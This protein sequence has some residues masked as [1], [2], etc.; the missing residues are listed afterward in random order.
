MNLVFHI[1]ED[2]SEID[3]VYFSLNM[4]HL[5]WDTYLHTKL[6]SYAIIFGLKQ[7]KNI[8]KAF[9][10]QLWSA[11]SLRAQVARHK[12]CTVA[13]HIIMFSFMRVIPAGL[14]HAKRGQST[15]IN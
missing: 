14:M 13:K 9:S 12:S 3:I 7:R 1:S 10:P 11:F 5:H 6:H 4:Q 2:G 15:F 8:Y